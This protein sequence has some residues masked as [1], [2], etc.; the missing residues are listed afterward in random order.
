MR[1]ARY[2]G[3]THSDANIGTRKQEPVEGGLIRSGD[4]MVR[5]SIDPNDVTS[6]YGM[7]IQVKAV[8]T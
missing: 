4:G 3:I 6:T 5:Q 7:N 2:L 1:I 8:S